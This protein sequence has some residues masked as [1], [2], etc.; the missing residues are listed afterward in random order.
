MVRRACSSPNVGTSGRSGCC[1]MEAFQRKPGRPE[2][3]SQLPISV[4]TLGG[5]V[6]ARRGPSPPRLV[7]LLVFLHLAQPSS[8]FSAHRFPSASSSRLPISLSSSIRL[9]R[10]S[11]FQAGDRARQQGKPWFDSAAAALGLLRAHTP[12]KSH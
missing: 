4:Q 12:K 8:S 1:R 7:L 10:P 9:P 2:E 5:P 3:R 11:L 6:Q